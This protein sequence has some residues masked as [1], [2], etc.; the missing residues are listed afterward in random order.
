LEDGGFR[1]PDQKV[2]GRAY[3]I[4]LGGFIL[5]Q[6]GMGLYDVYMGFIWFYMV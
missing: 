6:D 1:C 4:L 2:Q 3:W 5:L